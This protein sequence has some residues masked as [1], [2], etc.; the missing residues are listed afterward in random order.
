MKNKVKYLITIII[1]IFI[2]CAIM[3]GI[4]YFFPNTVIKSVTKEE[5]TIKDTGINKSVEKVF[6]SVIYVSA[7]SSAGDSTGTGFVYKSDK[8]KGYILTNYHVVNGASS[9]K[10][11]FSDDSEA[12]AKYLGG[13]QYADIAVLTI[14]ASMVK[15]I[16]ETGK[17]SEAKIGDTVFTIGAPMGLEYKG[18]VT[19]GILSGKDRMVSVS[20]NNTTSNDWVMNV[21]Q[22]DAAINPGNSGGP[23]CNINGEVIG[24]NSLKIVKNEVEGLGFSIPIEDALIYAE[25]IEKKLDTVRPYLGV[26]LLNVADES[27]L[28]Y[29]G[30]KID[31][32]LTEGV[33]IASTEKNSPANKSGIE[34]GDVITKIGKKKISD[35]AE[36]RFYLYKS[37]PG[38]MVSLTINRNGK[39]K[40]IKVKL[41]KAKN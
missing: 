25:K 33:V 15:K 12:E 11:L 1:C 3:Y 13:D 36:F 28:I 40:V 27:S 9:I 5:V 7:K 39:E 4:I 21:M 2:G 8:S 29:K 23:L 24:V 38:N 17:S 6:D 41:D 35:I 37:E 20:L 34:V 31:K 22:T 30:I 18:T 32:D 16:A 14:D 10:V 19:K 26:E